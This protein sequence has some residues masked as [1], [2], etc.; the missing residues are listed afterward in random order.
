MPSVLS[1]NSLLKMDRHDGVRNSRL[2]LLILFRAKSKFSRK[3]LQY[4]IKRCCN[5]KPP[6]NLIF[7]NSLTF[8]FQGYSRI[9]VYESYR[10]NIIHILFVKDLVISLCLTLPTKA[11]K[12]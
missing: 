7:D 9:P 8:H 12:L 5:N 3:L 2:M 10:S 11:A 4:F 1:R 6:I